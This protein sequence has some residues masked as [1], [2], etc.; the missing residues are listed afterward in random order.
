M[1]GASD[2]APTPE[3][4]RRWVISGRVQ[5]V[6]FRWFVRDQATRMGLRGWVQNRDG[7]E[8]EVVAA[9]TES[10]LTSLDEMLRKGPSGAHV[11]QVRT[12]EIPHQTVDTK[13]FEI[14][15]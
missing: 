7:G 14:R 3:P 10:G 6:G 4:A 15:R 2:N 5:G 11:S 1:S 13:S 8:V 12:T 9:G